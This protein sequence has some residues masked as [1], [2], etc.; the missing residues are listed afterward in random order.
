MEIPTAE[1]IEK[2]QEEDLWLSDGDEEDEEE[3]DDDKSG[4]KGPFFISESTVDLENSLSFSDNFTIIDIP[5]STLWGYRE[6]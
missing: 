1:E 5:P 6:N 3:G 2:R 4:Y